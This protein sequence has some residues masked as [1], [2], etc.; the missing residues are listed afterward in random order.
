[1]SII[2]MGLM[3]ITADA[4]G[5]SLLAVSPV[6]ARE[7]IV[8]TTTHREQSLQDVPVSVGVVSGELV[9][10]LDIQDLTDLQAFVP[11]FTVQN[12]FGNWAVRIR[13]VGSGQTNLAFLSSV[14]IFNDGVYCGRTTADNEIVICHVSFYVC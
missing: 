11:N 14:G 1:M 7:E 9:Q 5:G 13:G 8:V 6:Q 4:A 10:K 3:T 2:R 12:T